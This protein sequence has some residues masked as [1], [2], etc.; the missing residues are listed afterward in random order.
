MFP[1]DYENLKKKLNDLKPHSTGEV[2]DGI[3]MTWE[4]ENI[5]HLPMAAVV[6]NLSKLQVEV[7]NAE[8]EVLQVFSAASGKLSI[9]PDK[10]VAKVVAP[11]L[12]RSSRSGVYR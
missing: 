7:K 12:L 6:A 3:K 1:A 11:S 9:K 2:E 5:Y 10:L 8:A 4:I